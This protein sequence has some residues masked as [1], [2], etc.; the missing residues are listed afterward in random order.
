MNLL[1]FIIHNFNYNVLYYITSKMNYAS[2][3]VALAL[4]ASQ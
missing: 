2:S 3:I 4:L 1:R